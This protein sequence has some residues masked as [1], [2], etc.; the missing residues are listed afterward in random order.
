M[1]DINVSAVPL[2]KLVPSAINVRTTG[3]D[4]G[5]DGLAASIAARGLLQ[6]LVVRET[7]EGKYEVVAGGRRLAALKQL[8]KAKKLPKSYMV[9]VQIVGEDAALEASLAENVM[10][11]QM[12]PADQFAAFAGLIAQGHSIEDVAA[13][14]GVTPGVVTRRMK[15]ASLSPVIIE[16]FR[17]DKLT[18]EQVMGFTVSEDHAEQETVFAEIAD[19]HYPVARSRI[20]QML[21]H[22][23]MRS[24]DY[25]FRFV[26]E[27]AYIAAGGAITRD[28]FDDR[29]TGYADDSALVI[30]LA[31]ERLTAMIPDVLAQGWKWIEATPSQVSYETQRTF[32]RIYPRTVEMA[33]EDAARLTELSEEYDRLADEG[34]TPDDETTE[35]LDAIEAEIETLREK[36]E[37]FDPAEMALAGGWISLNNDGSINLELGYVRPEDRAAL[38]ALRR[39]AE[40][41]EAD[42]TNSEYAETVPA[43][44]AGPKIPETLLTELHAARTIALRLELVKR[45]D[46]ALRV[47]AHSLAVRELSHGTSVLTVNPSRTH[48]SEKDRVGAPDE[49]PLND[50]RGHWNLRIGGDPARMWD[51]VMALSD[52]DVIDLIAVLSASLVDATY[53]KGSPGIPARPG[54]YADKLAA[55]LGLDMR[56]HWTPTAETYFG[57]V[58]KDAITEAVTEAAGEAEAAKLAGLKK[59]AMAEEA[60]IIAADTTWL[61]APLRTNRG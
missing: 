51:A 48:I 29:D 36:A 56:Q 53:S 41:D 33:A 59:T 6:N 43:A 30:R 8:C 28:L 47:L 17:A 39:P 31:T 15:L 2:T 32:T 11:E 46:I 9:P 5:I 40:A 7:E 45:P 25:R 3:R 4:K 1:N 35:R 42:E 54:I 10:R 22:D 34:D 50:L 14:F 21:T 52:A 44:A 55:T 38:A 13:R 60:A 58:S 26:G 12:H 23:K 20:V 57:R 18:L 37:A 61:P 27:D 16:A 19:S 49:A 24:T